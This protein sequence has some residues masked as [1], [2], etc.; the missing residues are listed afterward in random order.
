MQGVEIFGEPESIGD[1]PNVGVDHHSRRVED[2]SQYD[3]RGFLPDAGKAHEVFERG[4][5]FAVKGVDNALA[6]KVNI[7]RFGSEKVDAT[8]EFTNAVFADSQHAFGVRRRLKERGRDLIHTL[9]GALCAQKRRDEK[10]ETVAVLKR[11]LGLGKLVGQ[12][13]KN[14]LRASFFLGRG[15]LAHYR[16]GINA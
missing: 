7:A 11:R 14:S 1:T 6:R 15:F 16:R 12:Q 3:V 2:V 9:I 10:L 5:N 8:N 13:R 4:R